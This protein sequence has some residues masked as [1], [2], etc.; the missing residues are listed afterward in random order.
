MLKKA[1]RVVLDGQH[2]H[3]SPRSR[4]EGTPVLARDR[5]GAAL[6]RVCALEVVAAA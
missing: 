2:D 3:G 4:Y 6:A 5:D 1:V